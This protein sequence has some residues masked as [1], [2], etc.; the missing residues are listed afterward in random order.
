MKALLGENF[1]HVALRN[2]N[3]TWT[4]TSLFLQNM[5]AH[6]NKLPPGPLQTRL[7][8][9][10]RRYSKYDT[11]NE[12][13]Y[14]TFLRDLVDVERATRAGGSGTQSSI[15]QVQ[16]MPGTQSLPPGGLEDF[17]RRNGIGLDE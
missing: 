8:D 9:L 1:D 7:M 15:S 14:R 4:D 16:Q 12:D 11:F 10:M 3:G 5:R 13:L 6:V 17:L 2:P